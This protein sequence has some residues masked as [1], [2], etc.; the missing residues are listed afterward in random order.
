MSRFN[1]G[2]RKPIDKPHRPDLAFNPEAETGY[3]RS[4]MRDQTP[5]GE[6]GA[7]LSTTE[8][9]PSPAP[10][11]LPPV[12]GR[13]LRGT[14]WLALRTP[15]QVVIAFWTV[16]LI[17]EKA[18]EDTYNA[19]MFAWGF[20]FFQFLFEFGMSSAIQ[21]RIS[22]CWT[23]GDHEG[24]DRAIACGMRFYTSVA[25]IQAA[26]LLAVAYFG[27]PDS[28]SP[29]DRWLII[30]LLW[31]QATTAGCY[32]LTTVVSA[33]LQA[34]R[35][36]DFIPRYELAIVVLRFAI[37][38]GGLA[39]KVDFFWIV[40]AQTVL[41]VGLSLGP[42]L[43]VMARELGHWP[44][45]R[46]A[47]GADFRAL[48]HLS[49]YMFLIQ[50]SVVLADKIDT[51]VLGYA[52]DQSDAPIA[53]YSA[54]SK[55][56]LQIRQT[57]WM[58]VYMVMPAVASL[59]AAGDQKELET[60]KYDGSRML[61]GLLTP[62]AVLACIDAHPFLLAWVPRFA[63]QYPLMRLFL[64][65]TLPLLLA[66]PVQMA[67]GLGKIRPIALASLAASVV[68]LPL[69]FVWTWWTGQV[70][71]VIWG[72]VLTTLV[73]NLLVPGIYC[74]RVLQIDLHTALKRTLI[75]PLAGAVC[76]I[77][78]AWASSGLVSADRLQ[79]QARLQR[80]LPLVEH[81]AIGVAAYLVGYLAT[82]AG[83]ADWRRLQKRLT[84]QKT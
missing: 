55:P 33:V 42:A 11:A 2:L 57:G 81:L 47:T 44:H 50:I 25:L 54:I 69:S 10:R 71:G 58:L 1:I 56:F 52:L 34:A 21:G 20:G 31:L 59:R 64:I 6:A 41:G 46:G 73:G 80:T 22:E 84:R 7:I 72:T 76:L 66:V 39:L 61:I 51:T 75:P 28:F 4:G 5:E 13:L 37:L 60:I 32:G 27:I 16:P 29:Q 9:P 26:A 45:F 65:A 40:A 63:D 14:M 78:A 12:L 74:I 24:V 77:A 83:R 38:W 82:P 8:T 48:Y 35:R 15:L 79:G 18:G 49:L 36:Y 19:Y 23:R 3:D 67:I 70:S 53:L 68:N 17:L 30:R 43:W 62:V